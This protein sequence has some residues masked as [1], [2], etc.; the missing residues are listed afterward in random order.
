MRDVR[1]REVDNFSP[2]LGTTVDIRCENE[3]KPDVTKQL[4][5]YTKLLIIVLRKSFKPVWDLEEFSVLK[6]KISEFDPMN[7]WSP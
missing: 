2:F 6:R 3:H 5:S 7:S 1:N 4:D